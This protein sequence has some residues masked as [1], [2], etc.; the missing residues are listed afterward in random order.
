MVPCCFGFWFCYFGFGFGFGG[1]DATKSSSIP[2]HS[3]A[4]GC[5]CCTEI[6]TYKKRVSCYRC[7]S[8][9]F[10]VFRFDD[11]EEKEEEQE[12]QQQQQQQY[13]NNTYAS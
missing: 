10:F 1:V 3:S 4:Y 5:C 9:S 11:Q 6:M 8:F 2:F 12:Q 7:V 13:G